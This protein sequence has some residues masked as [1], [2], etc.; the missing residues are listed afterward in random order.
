MRISCPCGCNVFHVHTPPAKTPACLRKVYL[1]CK[2][3]GRLWRLQDASLPD[4][5]E[6][7]ILK[8]ENQVSREPPAGGDYEN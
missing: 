3:C 4:V 1:A 5:N 2:K 6:Q 7:G 8:T